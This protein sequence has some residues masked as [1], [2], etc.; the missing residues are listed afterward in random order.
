MKTEPEFA[1]R[2]KVGDRGG[3]DMVFKNS[4]SNFVEGE[5]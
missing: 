4:V 1:G 5:L 3:H 2:A